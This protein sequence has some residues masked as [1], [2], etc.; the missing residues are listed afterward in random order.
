MPLKLYPV[1]ERARQYDAVIVSQFSQLREPARSI[2]Q[3]NEQTK[4]GICQALVDH[5][6]AAH[7]ADGSLWNAL[8]RFVNGK[9]VLEDGNPVLATGKFSQL[10]MHAVRARRSE[11]IPSA[12]TPMQ[13]SQNF[14]WQ[15]GVSL[16]RHYR[17]PNDALIAE[18]PPLGVTL[19]KGILQVLPIYASSG[20]GAGSYAMISLLRPNGRNHVVVAYLGGNLADV[21]LF[22][23][24]HGEFWFSEYAQFKAFFDYLMLMYRDSYAFQIIFYARVAK[25]RTRAA[26][27]WK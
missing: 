12:P 2:L 10:V 7:A 9:Q 15:S 27:R 21:A 17:S 24:N 5:W 1:S 16:R 13:Y 19:A 4:P 23:P 6:I 14:L 20:R 26:T 3:A 22:D 25:F 8:Y 11:H 18:G